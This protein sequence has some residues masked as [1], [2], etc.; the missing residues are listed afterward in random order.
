M[1]FLFYYD[2]YA[3]KALTFSLNGGRVGD[4]LLT[5]VKAKWLSWKYN[6]IL[7]VEKFPHIDKFVLFSKERHNLRCLRKRFKNIVPLY[8]NDKLHNQIIEDG[9]LYRS[10]FYFYAQNWENS[11]DIHTWHGLYDN[12]EFRQLIRALVKPK[13]NYT[14]IV[15]PKDVITVAVHVRKGCGIDLGVLLDGVKEYQKRPRQGV[16][17]SD[18][19]HPLKFPPDHFYIDSLYLLLDH[20]GNQKIYV[21]IFTDYNEPQKIIDHYKQQINDKRV[22]FAD[23]TRNNF[24]ADMFD[25]SLFD[26][27]IRPDSSFSK[28]SEL[29]GDHTIVMCP[30]QSVW[31]NNTLYITE[32]RLK[33]KEDIF[34]F[35]KDK[36]E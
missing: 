1:L 24:I 25:M 19:S 9:T 14:K 27:L 36:N 32:I 11:Q 26:F 4:C 10:S 6:L 33:D 23:A 13:N 2:V 20:I 28:V 17:P 31:I 7:Y 21:Q 35:K 5:Y 16:R 8:S 34:T 3:E 12:Q 30:L 22:I 15:I 29:V 18:K